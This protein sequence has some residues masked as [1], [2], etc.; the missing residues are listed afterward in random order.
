MKREITVCDQSNAEITLTLWG[1]TAE[2]FNGEGNPVVAVKV[3]F[4]YS[5]TGGYYPRC[6]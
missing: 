2:T 3:R 1:A 5:T 6:V 4:L